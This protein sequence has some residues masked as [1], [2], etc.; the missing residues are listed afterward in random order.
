MLDQ[1][2]NDLTVDNR[3]KRNGDDRSGTNRLRVV[4]RYGSGQSPS[5]FREACRQA[6]AGAYLARL[7][8][9]ET[10]RGYVVALKD[11]KAKIEKALHLAAIDLEK[12]RRAE[13]QTT[14]DIV[15][16]RKVDEAASRHRTLAKQ[17]FEY[18]ELL[19][20]A[21]PRFKAADQQ[22]TKL[23]LTMLKIFKLARKS[24]K[25]FDLNL[26]YRDPCPKYRQLC[27]LP[28][29]KAAALRTFSID[30]VDLTACRRYSQIQ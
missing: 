1:V 4:N 24:S 17:D 6:L 9:R 29:S 13:S 28:S 2:G 23:R 8:Q 5:N 14:F 25:L 30:G 16:A 12:K 27:P 18:E 21:W 15:L 7:D 10:T 20:A 22:T 19:A 26:S 11:A 3:S